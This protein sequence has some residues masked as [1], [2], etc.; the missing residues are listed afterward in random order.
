MF[1]TSLSSLGQAFTSSGG[2]A[3]LMQGAVMGLT[4]ALVNMAVQAIQKALSGL[5]DFVKQGVKL[6]R[7]LSEIQY[8]LDT[9]LGD[10][11]AQ[12]D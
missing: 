12:V 8:V 5:K 1:G 4:M 7:D 2:M 10:G 9:T 6:A 11:A 3:T